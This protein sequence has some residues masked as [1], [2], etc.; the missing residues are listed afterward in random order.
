MPYRAVPV[1]VYEVLHSPPIH[2]VC[3]DQAARLGLQQRCLL[4]VLILLQEKLSK[5]WNKQQQQST[6]KCTPQ[7]LC[8]K[9]GK[10][11][12][13]CGAPQGAPQQTSMSHPALLL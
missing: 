10:V 12:V 1:L 8:D 2:A 9:L 7:A 5:L 4:Q 6:T 11:E 3:A 13:E